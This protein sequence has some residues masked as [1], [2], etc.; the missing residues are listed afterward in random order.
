MF[1]C[2]ESPLRSQISPLQQN[3]TRCLH[4]PLL[5]E[6]TETLLHCHARTTQEVPAL[7]HDAE[8]REPPAAQKRRQMLVTLPR[9]QLHIRLC[10]R[11]GVAK[12]TLPESSL[13]LPLVHGFSPPRKDFASGKDPGTRDPGDQPVLDALLPV[14]EGGEGEPVEKQLAE[15]E[16]RRLVEEADEFGSEHRLE[17]EG[18][19]PDVHALLLAPQS[20]FVQHG[21]SQPKHMTRDNVSPFA[22]LGRASLVGNPVYASHLQLSQALLP[23][24][25]LLPPQQTRP[26]LTG[27][28]SIQ[29]ARDSRTP[30]PL[31]R[32]K[33]HKLLHCPRLPC[34]ITSFSKQV[35]DSSVSLG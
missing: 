25:H 14:Q 27:S 12:Q 26:R 3:F 23:P 4:P 8:E 15:L 7:Q 34:T 18:Y 20:R 1:P 32:R 16:E 10:P 28:D 33:Q 9:D 29:H 11:L 22:Q 21:V 30:L 24:P 19:D 13:D 35:G 31:R 17:L 5:S 6:S 2:Q